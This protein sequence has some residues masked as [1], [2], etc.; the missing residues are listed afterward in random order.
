MRCDA[1]LFDLCEL[2]KYIINYGG[3]KNSKEFLAHTF[4]IYNTYFYSY[5]YVHKFMGFVILHGGDSSK[6]R[7]LYV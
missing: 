4:D 2:Y 6:L 5:V 1:F 3:H 7:L